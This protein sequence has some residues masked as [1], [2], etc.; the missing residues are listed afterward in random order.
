MTPL[1]TGSSPVVDFSLDSG[2][3]WRAS[4]WLV[5]AGTERGMPEEPLSRLELCMT[6][7]LANVIEHGGAGTPASPVHLRLDVCRSGSGGEATVT[8]SDAGVRYDPL[9]APLAPR[10][11]TL[12]EAEPGGL[13]LIMLRQFADTLDYAYREGRN[14][15]TIRVRWN[16]EEEKEEEEEKGS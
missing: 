4:T 13:G 10:P 12:A 8:V 16:E 3:P 15:L 11:R 7:A 1:A 5:K 2:E 9:A 14:H 6:E